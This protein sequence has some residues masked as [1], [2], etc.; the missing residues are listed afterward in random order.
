MTFYYIEHDK[1]NRLIQIIDLVA[2]GQ[3][4]C[5]EN[6]GNKYYNQKNIYN[7]QWLRVEK[8]KSYYKSIKLNFYTFIDEIEEMRNI[9]QSIESID[10]QT[11]TDFENFLN[12]YLAFGILKEINGDTYN[13]GKIFCCMFIPLVIPMR[14]V[15]TE[16][17]LYPSPIE[18]CLAFLDLNIA[19]GRIYI[20]FNYNVNNYICLN[21]NDIY[22]LKYN[23]RTEINR[24]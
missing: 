7:A 21:G 6:G 17:E 1:Y 22:K 14:G 2:P 19:M 18:L 23:L 16:E 5:C 24:P 8:I 3:C 15:R 4:I 10:F 9:L 12:N 20:N 11:H 13:M